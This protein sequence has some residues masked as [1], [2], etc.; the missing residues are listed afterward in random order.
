[1][2]LVSFL[3]RY[4]RG[5]VLFAI[6]AG[7]LSGAVNVCLVILIHRSVN[8]SGPW[9]GYLPNF[10]VLV[11]LFVG[12]CVA[13][14]ITKVIAQ[15]LLLGVSRRS[16]AR[17]SMK[18]SRRILA[19]PLKRLER[20][21]AHRLLLILTQDIP[22]I[23]R[24]L[25]AVPTLCINSIMILGC[26]AYLAC[27][28][29]IVFFSI[30]AALMLGL[31]GQ[32]L[33]NRYARKSQKKRHKQH[34]VL[35]R[36]YHGLVE[37]V[38]ELQIHRERRKAFLSGPLRST[39]Q[40]IEK[41]EAGSQFLATLA[42][43][44][45]RF[46]ILLLAGFLVLIL[47][48]LTNPPVSPSAVHGYII[49]LLFMSGPIQSFGHLLPAL[50]RARVALKKVESLQRALPNTKKNGAESSTAE[51][52]QWTRL[53]LVGVT[54]A[55]RRDRPGSFTLGPLDLTFTPGELVFLV[56]DNGSGKTTFAKLLVGLYQ[57]EAGEIR[58]DGKPITEAE[59]ED[60]RQLFSVVFSDFYLF[61]DL[62][63]LETGALDNQVQTYLTELQLDHKVSVKQGALSTT[64]LS[65]GQRK[66]LALLTAYL[67]D[68]PI[69]VFDEWASDQDPMFKEVFY[70]QI[71]PELKA[72]GKLVL[73]ITHDDRYFPLAD[74]VLHLV[75]GKLVLPEA[76]VSPEP[77]LD[78]VG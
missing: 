61:A 45:G 46:M 51:A 38:K 10:E 28:S 3:L 66:R 53:E 43:S 7:I 50:G 1:M 16:T 41:Q 25:K 64:K 34:E 12:L 33:I 8:P 24:G 47:P 42:N 39:T 21:G 56:G 76:E 52:P 4:A 78:Q 58:L 29:Y 35:T 23:A 71:L 48:R 77:Q 73:V 75:E 19:T 44:S 20:L 11:W 18:L 63:G 49:G 54:H 70:T 62:L 60:Y 69:Y 65:R 6:L 40:A 72:R 74:R 55:Y 14:L 5:V 67:E 2:N 13:G 26:L 31:I 32:R 59:R 68:R 9:G 57:P 15:T 30:L 27:L 22:T 17:L 37:G 36:H